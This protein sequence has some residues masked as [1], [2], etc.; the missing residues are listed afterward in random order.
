MQKSEIILSIHKTL[1][2]SSLFSYPLNLSEIEKYLICKGKVSQKEIRA[3]LRY[4]PGVIQRKGYY[5]LAGNEKFFQIRKMRASIS[6]NKLKQA[7]FFANILKYIPTIRLIAV[8]GSLAMR[9]SDKDHDID[10]FIVTSLHTLW[11]SRLFVYLILT[12][13]RSN[14]KPFSSHSE[15]LICANMFISADN[16]TLPKNKQNLYSA[17]ELVQLQPV[18]DKEQMYTRLLYKNSWVLSYLSNTRITKTFFAKSSI[19]HRFSSFV[20]PLERICFLFQYWY[21]KGKVTK[22]T[23]STSLCML[24]PQDLSQSIEKKYKKKVRDIQEVTV[25]TK[26]LRVKSAKIIQHFEVDFTPGY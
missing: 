7:R 17:H 5:T 21:M 6:H 24:H 18:V 25:T 12:I 20:I 22:E 23:I 10:L 2:Y 4:M 11:I 16:L 14:R 19:L 15:D 9:N 3:C 13:F 26:T 1:I 8:S